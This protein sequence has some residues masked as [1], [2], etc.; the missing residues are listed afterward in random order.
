MMLNTKNRIFML[1]TMVMLV[2][3]TATVHADLINVAKDASYTY[4]TGWPGAPAFVTD[5]TPPTKLTDD[6]RTNYVFIQSAPV[7]AMIDLGADYDIMQF[8]AFSMDP[9]GTNKL[10]DVTFYTRTE[11]EGN[12]PAGGSG[13]EGASWSQQVTTIDKT[14]SPWVIDTGELATPV[15]GRYVAVRTNSAPSGQLVG[16]SEVEVYVPEPATIGLLILGFG[17][18]RKSRRVVK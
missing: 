13:G 14:G 1:L 9:W 12:F 15:T 5:T 10:T 4:S 8:T 2:C 7:Y 17:F 6:N 3:F 11:A 18:L 16:L